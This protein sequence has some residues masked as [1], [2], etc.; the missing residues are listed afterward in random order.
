MLAVK[1]VP[2]IPTKVCGFT[3]GGATVMALAESM[4]IWT[5]SIIVK[6]GELGEAV[7]VVLPLDNVSRKKIVPLA[8]ALA[9]V[10][11]DVEKLAVV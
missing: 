4:P 8:V 5:L 10:K 1:I 3:T 7:T 9:E 11:L 2:L 6:F